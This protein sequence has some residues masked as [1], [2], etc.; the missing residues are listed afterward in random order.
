M[1]GR[2]RNSRSGGPPLPTVVARALD[3]PIA[4]LKRHCMLVSAV[5]GLIVLGFASSAISEQSTI[6]CAGTYKGYL[7]ELKRR[8]IS[9]GRRAVLRRWALRIYN[10]CQTG[11][12]EDAKALFE[13]V[14]REK[15]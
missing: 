13:R 6:D 1:A 15:Y 10:A 8:Q 12:L 3:P 7:E 14:D 5:I 2:N 4:A 9:P 11:D